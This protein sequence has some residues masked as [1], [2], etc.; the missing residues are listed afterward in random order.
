MAD[1][2]E[3]TSE[4]APLV[5]EIARDGL[6]LRYTE[7]GD[8]PKARFRPFNPR[9]KPPEGS[10]IEIPTSLDYGDDETESSDD[11]IQYC[12]CIAVALQK[13]LPGVPGKKGK[14]YSQTLQRFR[15]A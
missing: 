4:Q 13:S 12:D 10:E 6:D 5:K 3:T 15:T 7:A 14:Y 9:E 1:V 2:R 11:E 8:E